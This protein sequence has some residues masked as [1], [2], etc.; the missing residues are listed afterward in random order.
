MN[1]TLRRT[2]PVVLVG[3]VALLYLWVGLAASG[4]DRVFG[5]AG[6]LL[7]LVAVAVAPRSATAAITLLLIGALP[8]A[9]VTWWS[10]VTPVLAILALILGLAA[11]R[12]VSRY[13]PVSTAR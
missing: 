12:N 1:A 9:V 2:W 3:V 4:G 7:I 10:I 8:L 11:I 5:L 6:G 13:R